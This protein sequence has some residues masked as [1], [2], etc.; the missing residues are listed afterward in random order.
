MYLLEPKPGTVM[1]PV[2]PCSEQQDVRYTGRAPCRMFSIR[3]QVITRGTERSETH[4]VI[5]G[6][7][8]RYGLTPDGRRQFNALL[9][10]GDVIG[11]E[12][13]FNLRIADSAIALTATVAQP[14]APLDLQQ[15]ALRQMLWEA[16]ERQTVLAG[17]WMLNL[18]A[19]PALQRLA[20][21]F[22]ETMTRMQAL[23]IGDAGHQQ[24]PLTQVELA[25]FLA[26]TPVHVNRCLSLLRITGLATF[27]R[28]RLMV[29]DP[30]KLAHFADS[31]AVLDS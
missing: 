30:A 19:R 31:E 17:E 3:E 24:L 1:T 13:L 23:G 11:L 26:L 8:A 5:S 28:G 15:T 9:L 18:G 22:H 4:I 7:L 29:A 27:Y 10:P 2:P 16:L 6:M 14:V 21:F 25:D 12:A 20:F